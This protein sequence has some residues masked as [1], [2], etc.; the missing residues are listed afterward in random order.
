MWRSSVEHSN[1][2][3]SAAV[4]E[5]AAKKRPEPSVAFRNELFQQPIDRAEVAARIPLPHDAK[6]RKRL[7]TFAIPRYAESSALWQVNSREAARV[8]EPSPARCTGLSDG[9]LKHPC[10]FTRKVIFLDLF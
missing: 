4:P 1:R 2:R 5:T 6:S 7:R 3:R 10:G 9:T 8:C